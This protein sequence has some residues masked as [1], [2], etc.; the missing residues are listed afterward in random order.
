MRKSLIGLSALGVLCFAT[1]AFAGF[2]VSATGNVPAGTG[3]VTPPLDAAA[4]TSPMYQIWNEQQG[5]LASSVSVTA[6]TPDGTTVSGLGPFTATSLSAGTAFGTSYIQLNTGAPGAVAGGSGTATI[7]FSSRIIGLALTASDLTN[8]NSLGAPGTTY[9][10]GQGGANN[11]GG[12]IV[13]KSNQFFT[14]TDG[15]RELEVQLTS[16]FNG[17]K[18]IRVFTAGN[19]TTVPEPASLI[20]WSL[21]GTVVSGGA[22][23]RRQRPAV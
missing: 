1:P 12:S 21:L 9:P 2:A 23:W 17:F 6:P 13:G 18:D 10:S 7:L 22:W 14:I 4:S 8:S 16:Q 11:N 19:S 20:V 15:G 3:L 5:T